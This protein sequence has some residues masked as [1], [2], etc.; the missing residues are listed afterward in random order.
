MLTH[1][2][3]PEISVIGRVKKNMKGSFLKVIHLSGCRLIS[4]RGL[5]YLQPFLEICDRVS[6]RL[7][8]GCIF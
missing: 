6:M 1:H 2:L 3:H 5:R 8:V 4:D 7:T